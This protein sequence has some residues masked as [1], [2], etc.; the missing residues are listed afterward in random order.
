M[1]CAQITMTAGLVLNMLGVLGLFFFGMPFT[2]RT[3]GAII[4]AV[5][6]TNEKAAQQE[7]LYDVLAWCSLALVLLGTVFQVVGTNT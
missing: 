1:T 6:E 2:I 4:L 7:K 5:D 3:G